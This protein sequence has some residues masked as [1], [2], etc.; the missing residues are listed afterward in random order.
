MTTLCVQ[1]LIHLYLYTHKRRHVFYYNL[2]MLAQSLLNNNLNNVWGINR[3]EKKL[4]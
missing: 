3:T 4:R 2:Y 1:T